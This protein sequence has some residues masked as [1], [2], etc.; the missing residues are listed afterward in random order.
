LQESNSHQAFAV[1][2][3]YL[4]NDPIYTFREERMCLKFNEMILEQLETGFSVGVRRRPVFVS[5]DDIAEKLR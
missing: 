1:E 5:K 2:Q 3:R 4:K